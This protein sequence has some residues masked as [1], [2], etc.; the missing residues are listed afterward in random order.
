MVTLHIVHTKSHCVTLHVTVSH[1]VVTLHITVLHCVTLSQT[2]SHCI[3]HKIY[4]EV[5]CSPNHTTSTLLHCPT[6]NINIELVC[7]FPFLT[8]QIYLKITN[9]RILLNILSVTCACV[10]VYTRGCTHWLVQHCFTMVGLAVD[11]CLAWLELE[12]KGKYWFFSVCYSLTL[13]T[14]TGG[15][16]FHVLRRFLTI[17]ILRVL[18]LL[19]LLYYIFFWFPCVT[20]S[21]RTNSGNAKILGTLGPASQYIHLNYAKK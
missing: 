11:V 21:W 8:L 15:K 9:C 5:G 12:Q 20:A 3:S 13:F 16:G 1:Y 18:L 6:I 7:I 2:V 17:S 14:L 10:H 19:S 4:T